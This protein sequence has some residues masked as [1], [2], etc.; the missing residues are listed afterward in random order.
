MSDKGGTVSGCL[1]TIA[2]SIT[3]LLAAAVLPTACGSAPQ[4]G[5]STPEA[6]TAAGSHPLTTVTTVETLFTLTTSAVGFAHTQQAMEAAVQLGNA[7]VSY[8]RHGQDL[9]AV[10]SLVAPSAQ[11]GLSHMLLSLVEPTG[12]K[13]TGAGYS[14]DG[15]VV[16]VGLLFADG[17]S[18]YPPDFSLTI[19]VSGDQTTIT[20]IAARA[21]Q[22]S[23]AD[24]RRAYL[25][26]DY[27]YYTAE[28][29]VLGTVV[30]VLPFRRNPLAETTDPAAPAERQPVVYK[31]YVLQVTKA[32]GPESIPGR[33][34]VY[35]LGNGSVLLDG[36]AQEVRE[37]FPL[38]ADLGDTLLIPLV[39]SA[40]FGTP[41][42]A[43]DEYWAQDNKAV[44][45]VDEEGRC[46]RVT[47]ADIDPESASR[48]LISELEAIA[49][50]QGK[51]PSLVD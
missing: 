22:E 2:T 12:C 18:V 50:E 35:A 9:A 20:G 33:I 3:L 19:A 49:L 47:G 46:T 4:S 28:A 45:A 6:T 26:P 44:F 25:S 8:V 40:R 24:S 15:G 29:V 17:S 21:P 37:E 23:E 5:T 30:K 7:A 36:A 11:E 16:E 41:E 43:G 10:Q 34:T 42:L 14:G 51:N 27:S 31:G 1:L 39:K 38:D 48:F 13:V 32:Y